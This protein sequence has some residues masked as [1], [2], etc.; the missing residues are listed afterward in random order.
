MVFAT[1]WYQG[2]LARRSA[3]AVATPPSEPTW[4]EICDAYIAEVNARM[5]GKSSTRHEATTIT[6]AS[7]RKGILASGKPSDNDET[8]CLAWLR[9]LAVENVAKKAG[10]TR[11]RKPKTIRNIARQLRYVFKLALRKKLIPGLTSNPTKGEEFMDE[12]KALL[13]RDGDR[14]WLLPVESLSQLVLCTKVPADRRIVYLALALT[15]LRP[16]ELAGLQFKH[17]R[18]EGEVAFLHVEQQWTS[19]RS[20]GTPAK[21]DTPKTRWS[22]RDVP[23]HRALHKPLAQWLTSGWQ[24]LVGRE[25]TPDDYL[26][27][28]ADGA[29]RLDQRAGTFRGHLVVAGS[30][31]TFAGEPLTPYALRHTFSTLLTQGHAADAAHDRLMGHRAKDTKSFNY[32]AKLLPFLAAELDKLAFDLPPDAATFGAEPKAN[33]VTSLVTKA[34]KRVRPAV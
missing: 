24:A 33:L 12:V 3:Q 9:A 13:A 5:R 18:Q 30:P 19:R 29:P 4:D 14:N 26:F 25:P 34:A 2:E 23:L 32:S 10:V 16:A 17:I 31:T 15:G 21:L 28:R 7:I 22:V 27:P 20:K 1:T 11:P 8:R 6:N